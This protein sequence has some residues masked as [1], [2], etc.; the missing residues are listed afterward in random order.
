MNNGYTLGADLESCQTEAN[1]R[2]RKVIF[3]AVCAPLNQ[4][5]WAGGQLSVELNNL[6]S[7]LEVEVLETWQILEAGQEKFNLYT[8]SESG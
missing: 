4:G 8:V 1:T 7:T 6:C 3:R 5:D 2:K